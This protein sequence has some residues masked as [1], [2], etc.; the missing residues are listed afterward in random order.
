MFRGVITQIR[1]VQ[2][3]QCLA[4]VVGERDHGPVPIETL[5][6]AVRLIED[7]SA[8]RTGSGSW[9]IRW[10]PG[11]A[12]EPGSCSAGVEAGSELAVDAFLI[13]VADLAGGAVVATVDLRDLRRLAAHT[14]GVSK[15]DLTT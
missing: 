15:V 13:A 8:E 6:W 14:T 11:W 4:A 12:C 7:W 1:R 3:G 5:E 10:I 9:C 2:Q